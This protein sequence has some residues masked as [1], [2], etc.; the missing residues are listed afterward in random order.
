M[1]ALREFFVVLL[2]F[3]LVFLITTLGLFIS[4]KNVVQ[5]SIIS[6][7]VKSIVK[8]TLK[9]ENYMSEIDTNG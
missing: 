5:T 8:D 9:N 2:S 1:K 6:T 7:G 4:L 3:V